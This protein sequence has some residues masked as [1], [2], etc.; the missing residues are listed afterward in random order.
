[1]TGDKDADSDQKSSKNMT[2]EEGW[3]LAMD[4]ESR[5]GFKPSS[6]G[7]DKHV[8]SPDKPQQP[9]DDDDNSKAE[10]I[11]EAVA[12]PKDKPS[13]ESETKPDSESVGEAEA[14]RLVAEAERLIAEAEEAAR[15]KAEQ[16]VKLKQAEEQLALLQAEAEALKQAELTRQKEEADEIVKQGDEEAARQRADADERR[17]RAKEAAARL[18]AEEEA[19]EEA[20]RAEAEEMSKLEANRVKAEEIETLLKAKEEASRVMA[21][22][23]AKLRAET[24]EADQM[25]AE[26]VERLQLD[27]EL[28]PDLLNDEDDAT[29]KLFMEEMEKVRVELES[30]LE[31]EAAQEKANEEAATRAEEEARILKAREEAEAVAKAEAEAKTKAEEDAR[32]KKAEE[33]AAFKA[34]AEEETRKRMAHLEAVAKA[35]AEEVARLKEEAEKAT[36]KARAEE[37][38]LLRM[39]EEEAAAAYEESVSDEMAAL[40]QRIKI[41]A[42]NESALRKPPAESAKDTPE[43][44]VK[45]MLEKEVKESPTEA[46]ND[47]PVKKETKEMPVKEVKSP[48][49]AANDMPVKEVKRIPIEEVK[50]SPTKVANDTPLK[51]VKESPIE[52]ANQTPVMEELNESLQEEARKMPVKEVKEIPVEEVTEIPKPSYS[53]SKG[54]V[55]DTT[56]TTK[57]SSKPMTMPDL[58]SKSKQKSNTEKKTKP[59]ESKPK[60]M[61]DWKKDAI[62]KDDDKPGEKR[63]STGKSSSDREVSKT[64]KDNIKKDLKEKTTKVKATVEKSVDPKDKSKQETENKNSETRTKGRNKKENLFDVIGR[65]AT[66]GVTVDDITKRKKNQ[67]TPPPPSPESMR[68]MKNRGPPK[69]F[70]NTVAESYRIGKV[71]PEDQE[72][73]R[74]M[75]DLVNTKELKKKGPPPSFGSNVAA[76]SGAGTPNKIFGDNGSNNTDESHKGPPASFGASV[77]MASSGDVPQDLLSRGTASTDAGASTVPKKPLSSSRKRGSNS[78]IID[79]LDVEYTKKDSV[80]IP[81]KKKVPMPP[82]TKNPVEK[83]V[84]SSKP[85]ASAPPLEVERTVAPAPPPQVERTV[86]PAPP[87]QVEKV[88]PPIQRPPKDNVDDDV[89]DTKASA[90]DT[91]ESSTKDFVVSM[92]KAA[93]EKVFGQKKKASPKD[94]E[95]KPSKVDNFENNNNEGKEKTKEDRVAELLKEAFSLSK[96]DSRVAELLQGVVAITTDNEK[97][98]KETTE[99]T[100]KESKQSIRKNTTKGPGRNRQMAVDEEFDENDDDFDNDYDDYADDYGNGFGNEGDDYDND[101]ESQDEFVNDSVEDEEN[102]RIMGGRRIEDRNKFRMDS[103]RGPPNRGIGEPRVENRW[104]DDGYFEGPRVSSRFDDAASDD[105]F[106]DNDDEY[107]EYDENDRWRGRRPESLRSEQPGYSVRPPQQSR[108]QES[109]DTE[110]DYYFLQFGGP[111]P[112]YDERGEGMHF[113]N[114]DDYYYEDDYDGPQPGVPR[115][116]FVPPEDDD[117]KGPPASFGNFVSEASMEK[118]GYAPSTLKDDNLGGVGINGDDPPDELGEEMSASTGSMMSPKDVNGSG[119]DAPSQGRSAQAP[120]V[121]SE[122]QSGG[123][124]RKGPPPSFGKSVSAVGEQQTGYSSR[125]VEEQIANGGMATPTGSMATP[126]RQPRSNSQAGGGTN[127]PASS[128]QPGKGTGKKPLFAVSEE[129]TGVPD[130]GSSVAEASGA[131]TG[132]APKAPKRP[133]SG[134]EGGTTG[135]MK[136]LIKKSTTP[137]HPVQKMKKE[138]GSTIYDDCPPVEST[139]RQE[140]M[141]ADSPLA[142]KQPVNSDMNQKHQLNPAV[143]LLDGGA[144]KNPPK[145]VQY[146]GSMMA[147]RIRRQAPPA[148]PVTPPAE[149]EGDPLDDVEGRD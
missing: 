40:I 21:E 82:E 98:L 80:V 135:G 12:E 78:N 60:W 133:P 110:D 4:L 124:R 32:R 122:D 8:A 54:E 42:S 91:K 56:A 114:P 90:P 118:T 9:A 37:E 71:K 31:A 141:K 26:N 96:E 99:E 134:F 77:A 117:P 89:S 101:L 39:S 13:A 79:V 30:R 46:A 147:P 5:A 87:L 119:S 41:G 19:R 148:Q 75:P 127:T 129:E 92:G 18:R 142:R 48:I 15:L 68:E 23:D 20:D 17:K 88:V 16:D 149:L 126:R 136:P 131:R 123:G 94:I 85:M 38:A 74:P 69:S 51:E 7:N 49:K 28:M 83:Q 22:I 140:K 52:A 3:E 36:A 138:F 66:G 47:T 24:V 116:A 11:G 144:S 34:K 108:D 106:V 105:F 107:F 84:P 59:E 86:A 121:V 61:V 10:V 76:A 43:K 72:K 63:V 139:T 145:T 53:V 102:E 95:P 130:F 57:T 45:E 14:E 103:R 6:S 58:S 25:E 132:W 33:D 65:T 29:L 44:E 137:E 27:A 143:K 97:A 64:T 146:G 1:M 35:K 93:V 70:G 109:S 55:I 67:E 125:S 2:T 112:R 111:S 104:S 73:R 62:S 128:G 120:F 113:D 50:E 81:P 100:K 115:P